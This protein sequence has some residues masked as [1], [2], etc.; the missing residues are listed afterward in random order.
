[1]SKLHLSKTTI[2]DE[3]FV[4]RKKMTFEFDF[5]PEW[6]QDCIAFNGSEEALNKIL[7]ERFGKMFNLMMEAMKENPS[8]AITIDDQSQMI[9]RFE[10][11][12][13]N[14][15]MVLELKEDYKTI[16]DG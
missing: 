11:N 7:I 4:P 8:S 9:S 15:G 16:I 14:V 2:I 10:K 12:G 6:Y 3:T 5:T 13:T 1:M